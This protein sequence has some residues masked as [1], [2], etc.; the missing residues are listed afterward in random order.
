[1]VFTPEMNRSRVDSGP[2][3]GPETREQFGPHQSLSLAF[4]PTQMNCTKG[5]NAPA[6]GSTGLNKAVMNPPGKL[7]LN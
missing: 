5:V 7:D 2:R 4:T 3:G 6:F 1:M